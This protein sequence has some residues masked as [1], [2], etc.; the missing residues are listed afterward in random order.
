MAGWRG[1]KDKHLFR[2]QKKYGDEG[3]NEQNDGTMETF[4]EAQNAGGSFNTGG[5]RQL[6]DV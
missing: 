1:C 2:N 3:T 6:W 5:G 4:P